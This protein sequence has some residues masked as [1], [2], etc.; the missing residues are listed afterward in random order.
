M[1]PHQVEHEKEW[2][3]KVVQS[4][5]CVRSAR[6][7]SVFK[8]IMNAMFAFEN[9]P[10]KL[11]ENRCKPVMH[12]QGMVMLVEVIEHLDVFSCEREEW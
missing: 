9:T 5:G 1:Y 6:I 8:M 11:R 2:N 4:M 3:D 7:S 10:I 12:V